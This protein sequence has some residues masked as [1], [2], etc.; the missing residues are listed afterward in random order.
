M[1][2]A[3]G[4]P[5]N[6]GSATFSGH[7]RVFKNEGGNWVQA[8]NDID[9]EPDVLDQ[10]GESIA[11]SGD[12]NTLAIGAPNN[13]GNA[14]SAGHVRVFFF[15]IPI[16]TMGEWALFILALLFTNVGLVY[17]YKTRKVLN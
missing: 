7:V 10:S 4:A 2:V 17:L 1:T 3:I 8:G 6:S 11:L 14:P 15:D 9:G 12:G 13:D 5:T 16:P